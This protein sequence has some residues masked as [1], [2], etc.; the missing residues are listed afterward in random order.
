MNANDELFDRFEALT[1]DDVVVVPGYSE[2]LP[3]AVDTSA[4]SPRTSRSPSRSSPRR[5]T[6]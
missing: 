3:D 6:R 4:P 2:T 5:W 1:F